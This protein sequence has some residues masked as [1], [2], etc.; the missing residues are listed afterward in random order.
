MFTLKSL[1]NVCDGLREGAPHYFFVRGL[2]GDCILDLLN[3]ALRKAGGRRES[4]PVGGWSSREVA[5][6]S[7]SKRPAPPP[8]WWEYQ[9][10]SGWPDSRPSCRKGSISAKARMLPAEPPP[11]HGLREPPEDLMR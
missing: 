7:T 8:G 6:A 11:N 5:D 10:S 9:R 4:V 1:L 3:P 2:P